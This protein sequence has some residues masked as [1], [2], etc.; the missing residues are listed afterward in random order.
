MRNAMVEC[1]EQGLVLRIESLDRMV[2]E[3][4]RAVFHNGY[5]IEGEDGPIY[6]GYRGKLIIKTIE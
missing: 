6:V 2:A 1:D 3:P 4:A 5:Q